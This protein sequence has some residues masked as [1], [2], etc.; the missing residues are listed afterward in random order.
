MTASSTSIPSPGR[1]GTC[2][3]PSRAS[4][5]APNGTPCCR[6]MVIA[7]RI[8]AMPPILVTLGW[9]IERAEF[10]CAPRFAGIADILAGRDGDAGFAAN[11]SHRIVIVDRIN[12]LSLGI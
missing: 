6:A 1:C 7:S 12:R 8:A 2:M 5:A 10:D 3:W 9:N 4:I 11:A